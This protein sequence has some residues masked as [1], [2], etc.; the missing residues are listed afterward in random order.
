MVLRLTVLLRDLE[1]FFA[2]RHDSSFFLLT[3]TE[4]KYSYGHS[5][6]W[7]MQAYI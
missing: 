5:S 2:L 4:T 7:M 3:Y 6:K 1:A